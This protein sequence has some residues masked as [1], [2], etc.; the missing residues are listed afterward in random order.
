MT[1]KIST[2]R[3]HNSK[4]GSA[5]VSRRFPCMALLVA[6]LLFPAMQLH[7][8]NKKA[9]TLFNASGKKV[10]Y[11]KMI[12]KMAKSDIVLFGELHNNPVAHWLEYEV[13]ES[14]HTLRPLVAGAE[15]F[16]ADIQ[17]AVDQYLSHAIDVKGLDTLARLWPN[18]KTDYAPLLDFARENGLKFVATNIPRRYANL[19][20]KKDFGALDTLTE[21]EKSWIAPLPIEYDPTLPGYAGMMQM[22]G[23][24]TSE[25]LPKAQAIKDATMAWFISQN[26][27]PGKL[28]LHYHGTYHSDNYEGILWY[29]SRRLPSAKTVTLSTVTQADPRKL[30]K[31][32]HHRADFILC[33][34]ENMTNTYQVR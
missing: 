3:I 20:F 21:K 17:E 33:V 30:E 26:Y 11:G 24:H 22:M 2:L 13:L 28:F 1:M 27:E 9:Y 6:C 29:L 14:L 5:P 18:F 15:M 12:R 4:T 23:P 19:V 25:T 8:Q 32:N 16:E 34:D 7:G 31:E 10:G